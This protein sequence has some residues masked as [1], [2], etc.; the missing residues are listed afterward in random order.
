MMRFRELCTVWYNIF[1]TDSRSSRFLM[2]DF[3]V[4]NQICYYLLLVSVVIKRL[5]LSVARSET[6]LL[7]PFFVV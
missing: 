7:G 6:G 2:P 3:G 1:A 5:T 4:K